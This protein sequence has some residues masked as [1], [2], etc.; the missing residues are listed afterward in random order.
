MYSTTSHQEANEVDKIGNEE[1]MISGNLHSKAKRG[2]ALFH[3][4]IVILPLAE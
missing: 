4:A 2:L 1:G 3:L